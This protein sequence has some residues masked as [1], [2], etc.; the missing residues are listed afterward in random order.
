MEMTVRT[1]LRSEAEW[2][3]ITQRGS[4]VPSRQEEQRVSG[5]RQDGKPEEVEESQCRGRGE[6]QEKAKR[7]VV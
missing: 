2:E 6:S 1:E 4:K 7:G 3:L 5:G